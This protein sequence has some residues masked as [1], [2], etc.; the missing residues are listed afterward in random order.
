MQPFCLLSRKRL[1]KVDY[2]VV[3]LNPSNAQANI[4]S[5]QP[6]PKWYVQQ[7]VN[8]YKAK[9]KHQP[10]FNVH[11]ISSWVKIILCV[12]VRRDFVSDSASWSC[13][14]AAAASSFKFWFEKQGYAL[15]L[16]V[17]DDNKHQI[18]ELSY[19]TSSSVRRVAISASLPS[20]DCLAALRA[21]CNKKFLSNKT[22][23]VER[24][25][26]S[27]PQRKTRKAGEHFNKSGRFNWCC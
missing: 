16:K 20:V 26:F 8:V 24:K 10:Q 21:A 5:R 15:Q 13:S 27:S 6:P 23:T 1:Y 22:E 4:S 2:H 18:A 12:I 7:T 19:P 9:Y 17:T 25:R 11:T 3:Q 14:A